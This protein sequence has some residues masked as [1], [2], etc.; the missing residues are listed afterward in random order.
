MQLIW[1]ASPTSKIRKFNI[2]RKQ[3]MCLTLIFSLLFMVA[4]S[5]FYF[6]GFRIAIKIKPAIAQSL[7]GVVTIEEQREIEKQYR[8]ELNE[9][10]S[11]LTSVENLM[12]NLQDEKDRLAKIATPSTIAS[13]IASATGSGGPLLIPTPLAKKDGANLFDNLDV[14]I[15]RSKKFKS[16][17][18]RLGNQWD[19]EINLLQH[20][21]TSAP[22]NIAAHSNYG[23]RIDPINGRLAFHS[24]IDFPASPGTK[25]VAGGDGKIIKVSSDS[26]YG[27]FVEIKHA[28]G[29]TS[30]YCH[31][32]KTLVQEGD[33]IRRGQ[34]I[35]QVGTSG[36][37][38]GPHLHY[39]IVE[40]HNFK[41]PDDFIISGLRHNPNQ[42]TNLD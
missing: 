21:P 40:E 11:Q 19:R 12:A 27:L 37:S 17:I 22:V 4:G 29:I 20:I 7:G 35:G 38:T 10:Q 18:E 33:T 2:T 14:V 3:L 8:N 16:S 24:G 42:V 15:Q 31:L 1:V 30:K 13:K 34:V 23:N 28:L 36:R 9:L 6:I 26:G 25:V 41:N 32:S 5:T 39:E